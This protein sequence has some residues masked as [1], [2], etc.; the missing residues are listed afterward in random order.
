MAPNDAK[1][2][3]F[4]IVF[5]FVVLGTASRLCTW[6][7]VRVSRAKYV[8]WMHICRDLRFLFVVDG[9]R[10]CEPFWIGFGRRK[11]CNEAPGQRL[12]TQRTAGGAADLIMASR[13]LGTLVSSLQSLSGPCS[14]ETYPREWRIIIDAGGF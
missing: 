6:P 7:C 1:T 5:A 10:L 4:S 13:S 9:K 11:V 3:I 8:I 14:M 2:N 12:R